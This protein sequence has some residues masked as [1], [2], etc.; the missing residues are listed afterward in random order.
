MKTSVVLSVFNRPKTTRKVF[1]AVREAKPNKLFIIADGPRRD[2]L[3]EAE[4]CLAVR[5]IF[6]DV[7]WECQVLKNFSDVNLGLEKRIVSG[8]DWVFE[9]VDCAVILEDDCLPN[10]SFFRFCTELLE[11]YEDDENIFALTGHNHLGEWQTSR[12]SYFFANYFDCWG[13]ATWRRTWQKFDSEM[14][15]WGD[16]EAR[17][18]VRSTIADDQQFYNRA[19]VLNMAYEGK[20]NSWAYPFFFMSLLHGGLTI[21]P[22]KNL[23]QNI[24]FDDAASNTRNKNDK[25]GKVEAYELKFPLVHPTEIEADRQYDYLRYKKVWKRTFRKRALKTIRSLKKRIM[26]K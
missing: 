24:G 26:Q 2:R 21:T 13:W 10:P 16:L 1:E 25:R 12:S 5:K 6:D 3:G 22:S 4:E 7:D 11:K 9:Q 23:I 18:K 14:K 19:R 8:L 17:E 15:S 20:V